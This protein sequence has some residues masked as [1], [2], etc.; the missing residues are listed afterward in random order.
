MS[1]LNLA[2]KNYLI[3]GVANKKSVAANIA[4][5]IIEEGGT[6]I[7]SVEDESK[8]LSVKKLFGAKYDVYQADLSKKADIKQLA[9]KV[10][11]GYE[12]I[13]G[14]VHSVAF[15]N[16]SKGL[17]PFHDID[18]NDFLQAIDISCFSLIAVANE[19]KDIIAKDGSVVTVS[20]SAT[21]IAA[22]NYGYMAPIKAAL[23]SSIAFLTKSFSSFSNIR[24]N[25]VAPGL[26]KTSASAGIPNYVESYLY[27]EKIIPRHQGVATMEAAR[28]ATF[29]LSDASSGIVAQKIIVDAGMSINYFDKSIIK[30]TLKPN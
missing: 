11:A 23:D 24:F 17:T 1:F 20:I 6:P 19:F 7:F 27:A 29:L 22:E 16:Y 26:L 3:L 14:I 28:V 15:A 21:S 18:K 4:R 30:A 2:N 10:S 12:Q 25:A 13:D 8:V 5:I 9:A